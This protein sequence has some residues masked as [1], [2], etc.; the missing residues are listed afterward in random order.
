MLALLEDELENSL[1]DSSCLQYHTYIP[2]DILDFLKKSHLCVA[3][4]VP[5]RI[6]II[7]R[8]RKVGSLSIHPYIYILLSSYDI[9]N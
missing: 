9:T 1:T 8:A 2:L 4:P 6:C 7:H 3:K 5:D